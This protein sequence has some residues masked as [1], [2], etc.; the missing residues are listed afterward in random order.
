MPNM[1]IKD[2]ELDALQEYHSKVTAVSADY[3]YLS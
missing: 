3:D 1:F 2:I